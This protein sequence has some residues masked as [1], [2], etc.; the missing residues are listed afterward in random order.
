MPYDDGWAAI[1]L[2][3]P[4]R[5]PRTEYSAESHWPLI[6]AVTGIAVDEHS[7]AELRGE[8]GRALR[9]AWSYDFAWG[10][11][12]G[13][14]EFGDLR[15]D[16]G[17]AEY[18]AGGVDRRDTISCPF[19]D[20]EEVLSFD[21]WEAYGE[22]DQAEL[23]RRF[24][25][26]Y[27][28]RQATLPDEVVTT[29][30]YTTLI[31]GFIDIFGWDMLLLAAGIDPKRFGDLANRYATWIQ[32]YFD[33]LAAA[34]V[35]VVMIHD[36][37]VWTSGAFI[38]PDWYRAYVFPNFRN[39]FAPLLAAGKKIAFTADGNYTEFIDDLVDV[40]VSG[41]VLEPMTDM[42]YIA[43]RYGKTHFF[44]G[45][46]DTRI[47]LFGTKQAIRAEVERCMAIG[48]G[49]PGFFL[50]VGNHIPANTPVDACLYY[51]EV[52]LELSRR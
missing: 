18:A 29:G 41:F 33:A 9:K 43:E 26:S 17:H 27:R 32:Q 39:Y 48:K 10:T 1:H 40:G 37:M 24:E 22:K 20:P 52:Y 21:P 4:R 15:T 35:P 45:N 34:D 28:N 30:I 2:E 25:T 14:G 51:N 49:K 23:T 16:M 31:S 13:R 11:L 38:H 19:S 8:A 5:V 42:A 36:D 6:T 7:P 12:I 44:I 47:L 50:A 3:M 46:A